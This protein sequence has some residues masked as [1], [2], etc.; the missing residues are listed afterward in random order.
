MIQQE[1]QHNGV[2]A[3]P[4]LPQIRNQYSDLLKGAICKIEL[5]R[6]QEKHILRCTELAAT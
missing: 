2:L 5:I 3:K 6:I 4:V 1:D